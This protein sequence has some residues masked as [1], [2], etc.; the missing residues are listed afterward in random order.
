[1]R[2]AYSKALRYIETEHKEAPWE[3]QIKVLREHSIMAYAA[4]TGSEVSDQEKERLLTLEESEFWKEISEMFRKNRADIMN[5]GKRHKT[6]NERD[7]ESYL[8][9]GWELVQ[10]YPRGD[11]AVIRLP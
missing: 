7:L 1:M 3:D 6:I 5:N 8:E 9:D 4:M 2:S 11:K 10:I